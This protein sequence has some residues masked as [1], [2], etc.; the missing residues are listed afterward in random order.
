V[1]GNDIEGII[2]LTGGT[3][4]TASATVFTL[5]FFDSFTTAPIAVM[6][7]P[8]NQ[9]TA[10]F[11]SGRTPSFD[12]VSTTTFTMVNAAANGIV[13]GTVYKYTYRV[14]Q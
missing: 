8:A 4:A 11:V 6:I 2:T 13:N 14:I 5:T 7:A 1:V 12:A 3:G 10:N 9:N